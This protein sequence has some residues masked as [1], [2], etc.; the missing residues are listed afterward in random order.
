MASPVLASG[1][2]PSFMA[3]N[4]AAGVI[5]A[6]GE[7][8]R[9]RESTY[10]RERAAGYRARARA[11]VAGQARESLLVLAARFEELAA[12]VERSDAP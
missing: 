7:L 4:L 9:L 5:N 10:L 6:F 12:A 11:A 8:Q 3:R 2:M 1:S